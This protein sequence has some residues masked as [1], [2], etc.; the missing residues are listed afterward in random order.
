MLYF[1]RETFAKGKWIDRIW[2]VFYCLWYTMIQKLM[3]EFA[4]LIAPNFW[5]SVD[6][7]LVDVVIAPDNVKWDFAFPC[8]K[9]AKTLGKN[10]VQISSEIVNK[11][12]TSDSFS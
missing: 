8:F 1:K 12:Q 2:F 7:I 9:R 4:S 6:E 11:I 5:V 10:P 3:Y